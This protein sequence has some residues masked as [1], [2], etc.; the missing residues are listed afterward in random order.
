M[1][2]VN[3]PGF[4]VKIC[5]P[6]NFAAASVFLVRPF[7]VSTKLRSIVHWK[8]FVPMEKNHVS[9]LGMCVPTEKR[10]LRPGDARLRKWQAWE[11]ALPC[12]SFPGD[13]CS[14]VLIFLKIC[15]CNVAISTVLL[16]YIVSLV[17]LS[18]VTNKGYLLTYL[19]F[20]FHPL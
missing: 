16:Y 19:L 17:R 3:I 5:G 14:S 10:S 8:I 6:F 13:I 7:V 9:S 20:Q 12:V 4:P 18:L 1:G 2:T 11:T 15:M